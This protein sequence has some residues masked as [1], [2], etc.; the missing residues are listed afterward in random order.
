L[1]VTEIASRG[2]F[3]LSWLMCSGGIHGVF[4]LSSAFANVWSQDRPLP[5][6]FVLAPA[7]VVL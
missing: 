7:T 5:S 6:A 2:D 1:K 3:I 4:I